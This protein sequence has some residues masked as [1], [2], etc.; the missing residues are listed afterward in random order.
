[1]NVE[2]EVDDNV[3]SPGE[4]EPNYGDTPV[5][6]ESETPESS[7]QPSVA[8]TK[9]AEPSG[10]TPEALASAVAQG[11][12]QAQAPMQ[13]APPQLTEEEIKKRLKVH[14]FDD[15]FSEALM[16]ELNSTQPNKSNITKLLNQ[17]HEKQIAQAQTYAYY[18]AEMV[19]QQLLEQFAPVM[20]TF[21]AQQKE[22]GEKAFISK[23][24][25][26]EPYKQILPAIAQQVQASGVQFA[27]AEQAHEALAKAAEAA[28]KPFNPAFNLGS[29]QKQASNSGPAP[30]ATTFGG[31]GGGGGNSAKPTRKAADIW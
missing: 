3:F 9:P 1:M 29:K 26:L 4:E 31:Q 19:K 30:N 17:M 6:E 14:S 7:E 2:T 10:L 20:Q 15:D 8:P 13:Q 23:F 21:Q 24:P 27:T 28:I 12:R 11:M 18:Q 25:A 16:S 22:Q 5:V